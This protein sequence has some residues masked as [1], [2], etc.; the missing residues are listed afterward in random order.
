MSVFILKN[1]RGVRWHSSLSRIKICVCVCV[2]LLRFT[3][4][5]RSDIIKH[6]RLRVSMLTL[7]HNMQGN[8]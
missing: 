3:R 2:C 1:R 7:N 5:L 4:V 8:E 6:V